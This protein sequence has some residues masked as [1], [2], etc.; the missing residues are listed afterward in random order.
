[1]YININIF[2][3]IKKKKHVINRKKSLKRKRKILF[4]FFNLNQ[5]YYLYKK[6]HALSHYTLRYKTYSL[7]KFKKIKNLYPIHD[8]NFKINN[9][10]KFI[11]QTTILENFL[12]QT[13]YKKLL[14]RI[15]V[16][17]LTNKK[18]SFKNQL[19]FLNKFK[20]FHKLFLFKINY[21]RK[22]GNKLISELLFTKKSSK[23]ILKL[24]IDI[25]LKLP[26]KIKY[27]DLYRIITK[28]S[29]LNIKSNF[30]EP[31]STKKFS[32]NI[33]I[34]KRLKINNKYYYKKYLLKHERSKIILY[35][36]ILKFSSKIIKKL[37]SNIYRTFFTTLQTKYELNNKNKFFFF[38][39]NLQKYLINIYTELIKLLFDKIISTNYYFTA[40]SNPKFFN[41]IIQ[42]NFFLKS[43]HRIFFKK[44][45]NFYMSKPNRFNIITVKKKL[46]Y[47]VY[48]SLTK[49]FNKSLTKQYLNVISFKLTTNLTKNYKIT[50]NSNI[51]LLT[52][53][54]LINPFFFKKVKYK[55][56]LNL[57]K[58]NITT[59]KY[60]YKFT[61]TL[62]KFFI[63]AK[64]KFKSL[65]N[66][67][68]KLSQIINLRLILNFKY[69]VNT[70]KIYFYNFVN[71]KK[72]K[73]KII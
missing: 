42:K 3:L 53:Y 11:T 2:Q 61:N 39:F 15:L 48:Y 71:L 25:N 34:F 19:I 17:K 50:F 67:E 68:I 24:L 14:S 64:N 31:I 63:L 46:Y 5:T 43:A 4:S 56:K 35:I 38:K 10:L 54:N 7:T 52:F 51:L 1:M 23:N 58:N 49:N 73:K 22:L 59:K 72:K 30:I 21:K 20:N 8:F 55:K 44:Y 41:S 66:F 9:P 60:F 45:N 18:S 27:F 47:N 32:L 37:M 36:K 69:L 12:L 65:K 40:N 13:R 57:K 16:S 70:R 33:F 62:N 28:N 29:D 6:N 26:T